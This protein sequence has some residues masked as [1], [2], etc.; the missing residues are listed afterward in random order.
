MG[1]VPCDIQ[2]NFHH[3]QNHSVLS[4]TNSFVDHMEE[5]LG[6]LRVRKKGEQGWRRKLEW[7]LNHLVDEVARGAYRRA[8]G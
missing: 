1:I 5:L 7:C 2:G 3:P 8:L 6:V 4:V